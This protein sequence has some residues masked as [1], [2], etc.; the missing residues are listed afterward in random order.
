MT[1]ILALDL[2]T[3]TGYACNVDTAYF[4]GEMVLATAKELRE[5]TKTRGNRRGDLR[6]E[7]LFWWL[8]DNCAQ[9][10]PQVVVFEDV[11][12]ASSTYQTQLWSA[13]RAAVW[14]A[15]SRSYSAPTIDC[16]PVQTLKKF[17]TGSGRADKAAMIVAARLAP[18]KFDIRPRLTDNEADA[19]ALHKWAQAHYNL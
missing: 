8:R 16:V 9:W 18:G 17:A 5:Q 12:F 19:L 3:T 4:Y 6:V 15:F 7:R 13:L 2:G 11:Q 14:L 1:S 10:R